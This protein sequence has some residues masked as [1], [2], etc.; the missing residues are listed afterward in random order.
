MVQEKWYRTGAVADETGISQ[1]KLRVLAKHGLIESRSSNGMLYIPGG[2]VERLKA[3]GPPP[4]PARIAEGLGVPQSDGSN[5]DG[6]QAHSLVTARRAASAAPLRNRLTEELY[7]DPSPQ[8]AKSKEKVIR[9]EHSIEAKRLQQ[10]SREIDRLD[11]E[12]RARAREARMV[13]EWRH[14][15]IRRVL[16]TVPGE[17]CADTCAS[18]EEL[19]DRVPPMS[20]VTARVDEIIHIAL[21]PIR[22]REHQARAVDQAMSQLRSGARSELETALRSKAMEAILQLPEHASAADMSSAARTIVSTANA[23]LDH[24]QRIEREVSQLWVPLPSGGSPDDREEAQHLACQALRHLPLGASERQFKATLE[25]AIAPVVSRIESRQAQEDRERQERDHQSRID[26]KVSYLSLPWG[27]TAEERATAERRVRAA[28]EQLPPT[29]SEAE[30]DAQ[31]ERQLVPIKA[32]I[33]GRQ[34][35]QQITADAERKADSAM[36]SVAEYLEEYFDYD[37][38]SAVYDDAR[39]IKGLLRPQLVRLIQTGKLKS[40]THIE[41]WLRNQVEMS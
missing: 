11:M 1:Y 32:A 37:S 18:V 33:D 7:A 28:L 21:R 4:M 19:L 35:A 15:H 23:A 13:Q 6:E 38:P 9:L 5:P 26:R 12:E 25:S 17:M 41:R 27:A 2:V 10:K 31:K 34:A 30:V 8:L 40:E 3:N 14:G 22:R 36:S 39:E 16:E 20:N 29:A 24:H